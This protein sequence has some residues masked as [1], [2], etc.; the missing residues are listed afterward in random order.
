MKRQY[1]STASCRWLLHDAIDHKDVKLEL[2]ICG[3]SLQPC[4]CSLDSQAG[5]F[6]TKLV[7]FAGL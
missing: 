5:M 3:I 7:E 1:G 4:C 2:F 6:I